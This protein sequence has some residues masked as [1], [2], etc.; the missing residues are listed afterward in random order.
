MLKIRELKARTAINRTKIPGVDWVVNPYMG[1][2]HACVYCYARYIC[3]WRKE[4]WGEF[5]DVRT[6][7][8]ELVRREALGKSGR[9]IIST[10]SDAYQPVESRYLLTRRILENLQTNFH[11]ILLTK[12][13]LILRDMDLF[14]RFRSAELGLTIT[15]LDSEAAGVFE[16]HAPAPKARLRALEKL[17]DEGFSTYA[18]IGPVLPGITE[19][20]E[21]V[22][23]IAPITDKILFEDLNMGPARREIM[24]A[25][26]Q[27]Y[28][29]LE[30]LYK[31]LNSRY[32]QKVEG[33]IRRLAK[34][35]S[36]TA[37]IYFKHT[38]TLEFR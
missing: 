38:G 35:Y 5:V 12:S 7:V 3:K 16:P 31:N 11:L 27:S 2:E 9:I 1:C 6:N 4:R 26:S 20:E 33:E 14:P 37:E 18:F 17:H 21:L 19:L 30:A 25:V 10:V 23:E 24:A 22:Q 13:P 34:K 8:P 32:W 29:E 28:P 36:F 15:T